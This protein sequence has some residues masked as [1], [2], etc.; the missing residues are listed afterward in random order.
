[1]PILL[2]VLVVLALL[3]LILVVV[4]HR[5]PDR[6]TVTRSR[7][8][9]APPAAIF[10]MVNEFARWSGWSPWLSA[11][12][13]AVT[14][15]TGPPSGVGAH[16]R[17]S[18]NKQVGEGTMTIRDS[19]PTDQVRIDL[20]FLRPF[21]SRADVHFTFVPAGT[22]TLV[23]WT[24]HGHCTFI[25]KAMHLLINMDAMIGSKFAEGLAGMERQVLAVPPGAV[26]P[27]P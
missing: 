22:G 23:T 1:M 4:I 24:M 17:W 9:P 27:S 3:V 8:M 18:G 25:A 13:Q 6:Y 16:Y 2:I 5:R 19:Q 12:P 7:T 11:D 10:P 14:T 15:L 21:A 26:A 20:V